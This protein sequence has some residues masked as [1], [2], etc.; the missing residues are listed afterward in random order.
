MKIETCIIND[1]YLNDLENTVSIGKHLWTI[2]MDIIR[3]FIN[4]L[5]KILYKIPIFLKLDIFKQYYQ[6]SVI[7]VIKIIIQSRLS[8]SAISMWNSPSTNVK[9]KNNKSNKNDRK[10]QERNEWRIC[11]PKMQTQRHAITYLPKSVLYL[12]IHA[13]SSQLIH[14]RKIVINEKS[15]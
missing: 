15:A 6:E 2:I 14:T 10:S 9:E 11:G 4:D 13:T 3:K 5:K 1:E 12:H 8:F 7:N